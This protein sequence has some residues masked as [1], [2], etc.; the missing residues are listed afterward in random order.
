MCLFKRVFLYGNAYV[1]FLL[2]LFKFFVSLYVC[3]KLCVGLY[4]SLWISLYSSVYP[5]I[6][7]LLYLSFCTSL[8]LYLSVCQSVCLSVCLSVSFVELSLFNRSCVSV[9]TCSYIVVCLSVCLSVWLFFCN[10][11]KCNSVLQSNYQSTVGCCRQ[12][13]KVLS[14][15]VN[16]N[17]MDRTRVIKFAE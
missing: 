4:M 6:C 11:V 17:M 7:L 14:K 1:V 15:E 2:L 16:N 3:L 12:T 5:S 8:C 9:C 10:C 13:T